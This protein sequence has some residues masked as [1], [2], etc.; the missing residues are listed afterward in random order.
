[1][2]GSNGQNGVFVKPVPIVNG[3]ATMF[4]ALP[5][6]S[7]YM[8]GADTHLAV[9]GKHWD[10]QIINVSN[11]TGAVTVTLDEATRNAISPATPGEAVRAYFIET[12]SMSG[13]K[14]RVFDDLGIE[15]PFSPIE[16]SSWDLAYAA[17]SLP[18]VCNNG[19]FEPGEVCDATDFNADICQNYGFD[20]GFLNCSAGCDEIFTSGCWSCGD[21]TMNPGESCDGTDL[22]TSSCADGGFADGSISCNANCTINYDQCYTCGNSLI[23]GAEQCEGADLNEA[24]CSSEGFVDGSLTCSTGC[25]YDTSGCS[26]CGD[27]IANYGETCDATDTPGMIC[28]TLELGYTGGQ[29]ECNNTCDGY[30]DAG[31]Y[32]CGDGVFNLNEEC[33]GTNLGTLDCNALGYGPNG[34]LSC[35]ENC[36]LNVTQCD[37]PPVELCGNGTL[38]PLEECDDGGRSNVDINGDPDT[39]SETCKLIPPTCGVGGVDAGESCDGTNLNGETCESLGYQTGVL[40]CGSDCH[41]REDGCS[42][43]SGPQTISLQLNDV[44]PNPDEMDE[45]LRVDYENLK[46]TL[47]PRCISQDVDGDLVFTTVEGSYCA[48]RATD[49]SSPEA[50]KMF[51]FIYMPENPLDEEQPIL[52]FYRS[53]TIAQNFGGNITAYKGLEVKTFLM[54]DRLYQVT[55]EHASSMGMRFV[56]RIPNSTLE[57]RFLIMR[58][59]IGSTNICTDEERTN[60]ALIVPQQGEVII[61]LDALDDMSNHSWKPPTDASGCN[62]T[63]GS[64]SSNSLPL[65]LLLGMA[66]LFWNR[67]SR[68]K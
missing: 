26:A 32:T 27:N 46:A 21:G 3:T 44:D 22:G 4:Y 23:E 54:Q 68:M 59:G 25:F 16:T 17:P 38:D 11:P 31:C 35:F 49:H 47:T 52:R 20:G 7:E 41:F 13:V 19:L 57:G 33:D 34:T 40:Y 50:K 10:G 58:V 36:T 30:E 43:V 24:T 51:S 2:I 14:I 29:L 66:L 56:S 48:I 6:E 18:P 9:S 8:S 67:R 55:Q 62:C 64:N 61:P 28:Q 42:F 53:G 39:C 5:Q 37:A 65:F 15:M 60:C 63:T 12:G 45:N 1:M